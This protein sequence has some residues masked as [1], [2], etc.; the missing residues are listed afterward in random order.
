MFRVVTSLV[1]RT[2]VCASQAAVEFWVLAGQHNAAFQAARV[3]G[4]V[5]AFV[6]CL[7]GTAVPEEGYALALQYYEERALWERAADL[8]ALLG[9]PQ[10]AVQLYLKARLIALCQ[11][12]GVHRTV[13]YI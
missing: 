4:A 1:G 2:C 6:A 12:G 10:A 13:W 8:H 7:T 3:H 9:A 5:P 11:V